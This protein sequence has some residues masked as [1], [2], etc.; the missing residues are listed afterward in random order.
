MGEGAK[1]GWGG[2]G[3]RVSKEKRGCLVKAV[4]SVVNFS[5]KEN[6]GW[7]MEAAAII[8]DN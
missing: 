4:N 2:E 6:G 8:V 5:S 1:G 7:C 3:G